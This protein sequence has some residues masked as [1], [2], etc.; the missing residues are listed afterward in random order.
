MKSKERKHDLHQGVFGCRRG[1]A[2]CS[3]RIRD[4]HRKP[5]QAELKVG[6]DEGEAE[7]VETVAA[8]KT[9]D[10]TAKCK[11]GCGLTGPWG[12]SWMASPGE[13]LVFKDAKLNGATVV[14]GTVTQ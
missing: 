11:D 9:V 1:C 2:H 14:E 6:I 3:P 7:H 5:G 10:L 12:F 13:K 4:H 8:G